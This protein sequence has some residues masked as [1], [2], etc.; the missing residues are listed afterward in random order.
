MKLNIG[1]GLPQGVLVL[2]PMPHPALQQEHL[3]LTQSSLLCP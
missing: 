1:G 3:T 2:M